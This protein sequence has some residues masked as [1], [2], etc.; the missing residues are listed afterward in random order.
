MLDLL[1]ILLRW[2]RPLL[3]WTLLAAGIAAGVTY[4][5]T[6]RYYA[7]AS[8]LPPTDNPAFG[9]LSTL[10]QQ[11]QLPIPGGKATPFLPTLY[12]SIIRSRRM[13]VKILDEF[14]LREVLP[15][16][17]DEEDIEQWRSRTFLKYTDEGILLV[18]YEDSDAGRAAEITNSHVR[19]LD[20]FIQELN[21]ARAADTHEFVAGQMERCNADLARAEEALRDFQLRHGTIEIDAQ[22]Q[23][24]L[25]L[26][27]AIQGQ[28]FAKEVEL[29]MVRQ[30][31][32][33]GSHEVRSKEAELQVLRKSFSDLLGAEPSG[34]DAPKPGP[35]TESILPRFGDVPDLA[36]QYMRLLRDVK[37]QT[38][39]YTILLQQ[40]E[41]AR[42]ESEN[43]THV[44]SVLDWAVPSRER[45]FPRRTR[46]V[47][48]AALAAF[49]WVAIFALLVEKLRERRADAAEAA[50][51]AALRAEW[52]R[53]PAW[54][55]SLERL[56][57]K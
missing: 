5:L 55:R 1:R 35:E 47:I 44:I 56:V 9:S 11:Y 20:L 4:T 37:V 46:I 27:A 10:L 13:G 3:V 17:D 12:A 2:R 30:H 39:M 51:L 43:R 57:V 24:A 50:R 53:M 21:S 18:G 25:E 40:L 42:V 45:V 33:P 31:A 23:G 41:Q 22:T 32:L 29:G 7:Q 28:I 34:L 14:A 8:I 16:Q 54:I 19:N 52:A 36:L 38:T 26:G 15:G 6:P 48:V 49:A